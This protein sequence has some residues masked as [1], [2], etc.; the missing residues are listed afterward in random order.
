MSKLIRSEVSKLRKKRDNEQQRHI[1]VASGRAFLLRGSLQPAT[2]LL[3]A[4][5]HCYRMQT[6][7]SKYR[8]NPE[9]V[10]YH[11]MRLSEIL[12]F[13]QGGQ[14]MFALCLSPPQAKSGTQAQPS[15]HG[16][17]FYPL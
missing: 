13:S 11:C 2:V 16:F 10:N 7:E 14:V 3:C 5:F 4:D 15:E 6:W 12:V 9:F 8:G 1:Y 17:S